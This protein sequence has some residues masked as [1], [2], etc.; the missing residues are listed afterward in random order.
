MIAGKIKQMKV[1]AKLTNREVSE[2]SGVPIAT[3][4][5]VMSDQV[6]NP[7]FETISAIVIALGGSLDELVDN[8]PRIFTAESSDKVSNE[9][10][11]AESP[12]QS[13]ASS[14]EYLSD[15]TL[16]VYKLLLDEREKIIEAKNK[17]IDGKDQW[18]QR[19]FATSC[20]LVTVI[21]AVLIF[22]LI[23]PGVGFFRQ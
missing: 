9:R 3:V 21:I 13:N 1:Q 8:N 20:I 18:I 5:R 16:N 2:K 14:S 19:L 11:T 4:N 23:N 6:R 10:K 12:A 22:D 15:E 7:T 17:V